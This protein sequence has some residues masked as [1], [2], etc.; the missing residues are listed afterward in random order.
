MDRFGQKMSQEFTDMWNVFHDGTIEQIQGHVPGKLQLQI[1]VEY[2]RERIPDEGNAFILT[3]QDC[4]QFVYQE[5]ESNSTEERLPVIQEKQLGVLNAEKLDRGSRVFMET[6]QLDLQ[7]ESFLLQLDSGRQLSIDE[8]KNVAQ[9]Y[10]T[11]WQAK[12]NSD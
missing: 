9:A 3:L 7:S 4:S 5:Y 8:L 2:L 6:G 12:S 10:W 1:S 11:E